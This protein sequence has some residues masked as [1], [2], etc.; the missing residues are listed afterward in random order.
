MTPANPALVEPSLEDALSAV[1]QALVLPEATRSQ[2]LCSLRQISKALDR[3]LALLPA[4]WTALRIPV[5][6]LHHAQLGISAKT[7]ANHK[8]NLKAALRW[9]HHETGGP[10]R[11]AP[12]IPE[13]ATLRDGIKDHGPR[14]RLYGLMRYCSAK[15]ILPRHVPDEVVQ[16]YLE[17]GRAS[18]W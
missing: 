5:D 14:A 7:L 11:G 15:G 4:R 6:R 12:L 10:V 18:G 16:S 3:P 2:W 9:L 1:R 17:I 13:W 8:A